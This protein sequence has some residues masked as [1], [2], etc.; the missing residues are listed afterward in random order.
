VNT[1]PEAA[2]AVLELLNQRGQKFHPSKFSQ[3]DR[4][5][6]HKI[7]RPFV[8]VQPEDLFHSVDLHLNNIAIRKEIETA[9]ATYENARTFLAAINN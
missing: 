4:E 2:E 7:M 9:K 5:A 6:M 8:E 1:Q 3:N